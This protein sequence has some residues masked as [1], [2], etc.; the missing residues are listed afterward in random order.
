MR[1][2]ARVVRTSN[3]TPRSL[4]SRPI[5]LLTAEGVIACSAAAAVKLPASATVTNTR[6][7]A[8]EIGNS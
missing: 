6:A 2:N 3:R 5:A 1:C 4:S 7:S 8:S